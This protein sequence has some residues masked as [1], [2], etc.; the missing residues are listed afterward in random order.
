MTPVCEGAGSHFAL[1]Q[2]L[3]IFVLWLGALVISCETIGQDSCMLAVSHP[4][5][6]LRTD[7]HFQMCPQR[8]SGHVMPLWAYP[9]E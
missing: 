1:K 9:N 2:S 3:V 8:V 5:E 6:T 4:L 7:Q